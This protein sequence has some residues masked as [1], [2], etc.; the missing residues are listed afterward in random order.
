MFLHKQRRS[1]HRES[2]CRVCMCLHACAHSS[3]FI[4]AQLG[5]SVRLFFLRTLARCRIWEAAYC[6]WSTI[7]CQWLTIGSRSEVPLPKQDPLCL[8]EKSA[9]RASVALWRW[10]W[11][12]WTQLNDSAL[13]VCPSFHT[14]TYRLFKAPE[15]LASKHTVVNLSDFIPIWFDGFRLIINA[16]AAWVLNSHGFQ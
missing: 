6:Q 8:F 1:W 15:S 5:T 16:T 13:C 7:V 11:T 9:V 2:L 12:L 3:V 10:V 4:H 14:E